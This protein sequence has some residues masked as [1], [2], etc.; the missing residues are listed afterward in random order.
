MSDGYFIVKDGDIEIERNN[1]QQCVFGSGTSWDVVDASL[2]RHYP[3]QVL[4]VFLSH[5]GDHA[6]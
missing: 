5:M 4:R 2:R 1:G 6:F 3:D